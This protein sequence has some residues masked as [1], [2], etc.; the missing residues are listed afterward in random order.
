MCKEFILVY[1]LASASLL[2][3][4]PAMVLSDMSD[5]TR[6]AFLSE[7]KV[8]KKQIIVEKRLILNSTFVSNNRKVAIINDNVVS[9]GDTVD[10]AL[11]LRIS[12]NFVQ[13]KRNRKELILRLNLSE[14]VKKPA[15]LTGNTIKE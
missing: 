4:M 11:I 15:T 1:G 8:I 3:L 12:R 6:P 7:K 2:M 5:P 9:E 10:N 14:D 13:V